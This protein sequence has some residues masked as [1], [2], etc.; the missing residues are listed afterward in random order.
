MDL[1][2]SSDDECKLPLHSR[3]ENTYPKHKTYNKN[4]KNDTYTGKIYDAASLLNIIL[5]NPRE[6]HSVCETVGIK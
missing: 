1:V 2:S 5:C 3:E 4:R 6:S